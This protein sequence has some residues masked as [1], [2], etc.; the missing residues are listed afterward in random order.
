MKL[1]TRL[2]LIPTLVAF[3]VATAGCGSSGTSSNSSSNNGGNP[4][5]SP[6]PTPSSSQGVQ[7]QWTFTSTA[8]GMEAVVSANITNSGNN[9]FFASPGNVAVCPI[10]D[11]GES[12]AQMAEYHDA[13]CD[14][15][16]ASLNGTITAPNTVNVTI[17]NIQFEAS[18][19]RP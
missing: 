12:P 7:G 8:D 5:P 14:I 18:T 17:S 16:E 11:P 10:S 13:S 9:T 6:S 4:D 2:L 15:S 19:L 3:A 1:I